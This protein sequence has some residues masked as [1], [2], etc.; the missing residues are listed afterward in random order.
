[1]KIVWISYGF[2]EYSVLHV[3]ALCEEHDVLLVMPR[4][5]DGQTEFEIDPRVQQYRFDKPRLREPM[6]QWSSVRGIVSCVHQFKPDVVHFQQGHLW[7][8]AAL[9]QLKR[10]PLVITVHDPRHH[11]GDVDS[12]KTPQWWMD[13]GFRKADHVI[14]H[15]ETLA[16]EVNRLFG[17]PESHVH[18]IPHVAMGSVDTESAAAEEPNNILFFGRIWEYKGLQTLIAA[19]PLISEQ[20]P[21]FKIVIGGAGDDF[22]QYTQAM[23]NPER[24]EVHNRWIDDKERAS[25]FQRA[26]MV[27][28]PYNEA[29]QSGVVPVA[30]NYAKPVVAT[31][32]GALIE[33]VDDKQT[34]LLVPPRDPAALAEAIVRL[35][36]N[37]EERRSMGLAG[38]RML[39]RDWSP[40]V[41]AEQTANV[42]QKAIIGRDDSSMSRSDIH[43]SPKQTVASRP[44]RQ[45]TEVM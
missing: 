43:R 29:T 30:F 26:S 1:M 14:V 9:R 2:E 16:V 22:E 18:V 42:Y 5:E 35:L 13:Y 40:S 19:E 34:G 11:A 4:A 24:F 10:Y 39:D 23:K 33:C 31:R 36:K 7:F 38:K 45:P 20:V 25:F 6:K 27:V 12:L 32:V 3:N 15:G 17:F 37:P 44:A 21:D 41:V 28:L 8:N